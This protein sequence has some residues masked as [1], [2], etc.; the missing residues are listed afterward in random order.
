MVWHHL[1]E[2]KITELYNIDCKDANIS[3]NLKPRGLWLS[4][5]NE[6]QE[7]NDTGEPGGFMFG[8]YKYKYRVT[9][10]KNINVLKI[11]TVDELYDFNKK[12]GKK[13]K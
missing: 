8:N 3:K 4:Y 10:K 1:S 6:W 7:W 13:I 12:Y 11:E 2:E 9:F 5:N